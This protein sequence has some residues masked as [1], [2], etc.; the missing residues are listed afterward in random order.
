MTQPFSETPT[1]EILSREISSDVTLPVP[2]TGRKGFLPFRT[3][4]WDRFFV[5]VLC[6]VAINLLWMRF[7]E[8]YLFPHNLW[9]AVILSIALAVFIIRRG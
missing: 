8:P 2:K 1:Q 6:Y 9:I 3:N 5:S 7:V 4:T